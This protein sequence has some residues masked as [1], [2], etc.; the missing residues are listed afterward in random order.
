METEVVP[1]HDC[2]TSAFS[3]IE[4]NGVPS[5]KLIPVP[6]ELHQKP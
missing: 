3:G 6:Q 2:V 5:S 4:D 1:L